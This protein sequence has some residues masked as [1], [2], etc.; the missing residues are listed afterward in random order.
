MSWTRACRVGLLSVLVL[1]GCVASPPAP[2]A[3][4]K[5]EARARLEASFREAVKAMEAGNLTEA[6]AR[7]GQLVNEHPD[8]AGPMVNLGIIAFRAGESDTASEW[9][10]RALTVNPKQI[11]A[12]NHLGVIARN[13]GEFADAE[14]YYRAALASDPDYAPALLNLAFLLDIYLGRPAEA[15]PLYERYQSVA[16]EPDKRLEDWIFDAKNRR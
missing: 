15:V 13:A 4:G 6:R 9:F 10:R 12:L 14:Q 8:K 5:A 7:F 16:R 1:S 3:A 11:A 2:E